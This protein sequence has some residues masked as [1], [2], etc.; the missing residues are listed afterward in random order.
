MHNKNT[1]GIL[2]PMQK[3]KARTKHAVLSVFIFLIVFFISI[4]SGAFGAP[5]I[6]NL[7]AKKK[8][9][10]RQLNALD[11]E[12]DDAVEQYNES[13]W[14]LSIL[15]KRSKKLEAEIKKTESQIAVLEKRIAKRARAVYMMK[16]DP[17]LEAIVESESI[18]D[19]V[20]GLRMLNTVLDTEANLNSEYKEKKAKLENDK[21]ELSF[22]LKEQKRLVALAAAKKKSIEAK[23]REK[24]RLLSSIDSQLREAISRERERQRVAYVPSVSYTP[25]GRSYVSRG[26]ERDEPN[27]DVSLGRQA[28]SI[29]YSLLGRPYRWGASGP[30]AFDC[31]GL[32]MYV[33]SQ[34]GIYLPHSSSAQYYS[35]R[36]VSYDELAPGDLVFFARRSGRISHVGI[37]IGGGMMIHAPQTG[38]VVRVV[39]L[40][41][42]GGYVG[43]VR[44]Y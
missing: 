16:T 1:F 28:V 26:D 18:T 32:T 43:A 25:R 22:N 24:Q 5:S 11:A 35:G 37:Y 29:A 23:V 20:A 21:K 41:N 9:V 36:R 7:K 27:S 6:S 17:V 38:D 42:H 15:K 2:L 12:L 19:I 13:V 44:P 4:P 40:S 33:Y 10:I 31:S 8:E 39:P 14:K 3:I 34:L 30:G